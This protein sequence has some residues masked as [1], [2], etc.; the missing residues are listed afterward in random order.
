MAAV[1]RKKDAM[2]LPAKKTMNFVR[3]KSSF[4]PK[5]W[6][7]WAMLLMMAGLLFT[8]FGILDPLER[9]TAAYNELSRKQDQLLAAAARL[10]G[11]EELEQQYGRYGWGWMTDEEVNLADPVA[12]LELVEEEIAPAAVIENMAL[13]S[14]VLTMNIRG[15]TLDQA[16][17]MIRSLEQ[18]PLVLSAT[19][20]NAVAQEAEEA[21]I[22][23]TILLTGEGA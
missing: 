10:E 14:N 15:I 4:D 3:R 21:Q 1:T 6:V 7:V 16:G 13:N 23:L 9:K 17:A 22:F 8:K 2:R 5:K 11:Y 20:Y 18:S 12:V 19:I